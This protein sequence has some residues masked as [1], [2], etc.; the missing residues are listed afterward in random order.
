[1]TPVGVTSLG[2]IVNIALGVVKI[3]VG[4]ATASQ[5]L[6]ADG[7]HSVSDLVTD[8]AV[9]VGLQVS[10]KPPDSNH[11]FGHRRVTTIVTMFVGAA[12]LVTAG[13]IIYRAIASHA[14][15]HSTDGMGLAFLV[16]LVSVAPKEYLFRITVSVGRRTG[17]SSV[18]ANAWHHRTDAFTSVAAAVGLGGI[19]LGGP[20]FAFL[21]HLT[22]VVLSSFL[23]V[24]SLRFLRDSANEL[25]DRA[26]MRATIESIER[27]ISE[28]SGVA[29]F[30]ALRVRGAGGMLTL[31]VHVL[32]DPELSVVE[33]HD[34][35]TAVRDRILGCG[36]DV[37]DAIVH[38][39]PARQ[40]DEQASPVDAGGRR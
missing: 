33:G 24:T 34:V 5:A 26:P 17:D 38:V 35:A 1:M 9:L 11:H 32:V 28:T 8:A 23:I 30:H 6:L 22:A 27:T 20:R 14:E 16:A 25:V 19:V 29:G 40:E 13:W 36:C 21:D 7:L 2:I 12:L 37:L 10:G 3:G 15:I 39:E 18:L 31:D 4:V